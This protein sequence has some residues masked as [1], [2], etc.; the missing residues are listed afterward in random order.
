MWGSLAWEGKGCE[1][2]GG[3]EV[4]SEDGGVSVVGWVF[5]CVHGKRQTIPCKDISPRCL[6]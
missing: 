6:L 5:E 1:C 4:A 2:K 3:C